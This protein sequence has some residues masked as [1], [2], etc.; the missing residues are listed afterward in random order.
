MICW[1]AGSLI[2][3]PAEVVALSPDGI[4]KT[5]HQILGVG[6][7]GTGHGVLTPAASTWTGGASR[8]SGSTKHCA[9]LVI[10]FGSVTYAGVVVPETT[11]MGSNTSVIW[12]GLM[13]MWK[14]CEM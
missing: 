10:D 11:A 8:S 1:P 2:G 7:A 9:A 12:K 5:S 6:V 14:G 4:G 13:W 3:C